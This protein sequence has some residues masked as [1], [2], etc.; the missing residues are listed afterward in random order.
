MELRSILV[1]ERF[2]LNSASGLSHKTRAAAAAVCALVQ[3]ALDPPV[4]WV[5]WTHRLQAC[6]RSLSLQAIRQMSLCKTWPQC[7]QNRSPKNWRARLL[8]IGHRLRLTQGR[9][10]LSGWRLPAI[11]RQTL[12]CWKSLPSCAGAKPTRAP[13]ARRPE[14]RP[15]PRLSV[16]PAGRRCGARHQMF[17]RFPI[18]LRV[19]AGM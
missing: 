13:R 10:K 16:L 1:V 19:G 14:A 8:L 6:S 3:C 2:F 11:R 4:Q 7:M 18:H 15:R 5:N 17:Q 9:L 12:S